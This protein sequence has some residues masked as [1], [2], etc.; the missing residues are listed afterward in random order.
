MEQ[1]LMIGYG[2]IAL[3]AVLLTG[4]AIYRAYNSRDRLYRRRIDRENRDYAAVIQSR[5]DAIGPDPS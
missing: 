4:V 3:M 2:L 5:R 1:R